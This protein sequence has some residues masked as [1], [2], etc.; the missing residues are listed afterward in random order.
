M[1]IERAL[2]AADPFVGCERSP[3]RTLEALTAEDWAQLA[4]LVERIAEHVGPFGHWAPAEKTGENSYAMGYAVSGALI[5]EARDFAIGHDFRLPGLDH[6]AWY[7]E[8]HRASLEAAVEDYRYA[9]LDLVLGQIANLLGNDYFSG[10][11]LLGFDDGTMPRL[12]S[13]L[14]DFASA[15]S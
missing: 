3:E 12:L 5:D 13:R 2:D 1:S 15:D 14:L 4:S 7:S 8:Y 10:G 11:G 6:A 9:S